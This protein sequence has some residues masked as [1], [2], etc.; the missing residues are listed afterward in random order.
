MKVLQSDDRGEA[1]DGDHG[2]LPGNILI[3]LGSSNRGIPELHQME[4]GGVLSNF[5]LDG[6]GHRIGRVA[7]PNHNARH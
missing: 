1:N 4:F 7:I 6:N 5:Q 2:S 3:R